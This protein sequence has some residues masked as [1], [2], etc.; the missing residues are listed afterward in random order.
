M[1]AVGSHAELAQVPDIL[2]ILRPFIVGLTRTRKF[3]T[4]IAWATSL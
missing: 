1:C 4:A 2:L 3:E